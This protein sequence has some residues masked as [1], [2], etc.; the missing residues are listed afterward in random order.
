MSARVVVAAEKRPADGEPGRE[1]DLL[2]LQPLGAGQEVGRS[3]HILKFKG[4]TIMASCGGGG[5]GCF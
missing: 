4:R 3:C 2:T 5:R 1:E